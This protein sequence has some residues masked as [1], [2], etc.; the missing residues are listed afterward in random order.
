[1][2]A[3]ILHSASEREKRPISVITPSCDIRIVTSLAAMD[4]IG[5]AWQAL[6]ERCD[7]P[8][9]YFQSFSWCRGWVETFAAEGKAP[10]PFIVTAWRGRE[11]VAIW[12]LMISAAP[13]GVR[14]IETLGEPLSQYCNILYDAERMDDDV[15]QALIAPL[16]RP[17][18]CE[19]AVLNAIPETSPLAR[20]LAFFPPL[21]AYE[22]QSSILDLSVFE[23]SAHYLAGLGKVQK[24][25]RNR[26]RNKL[27]RLGA[28]RLDV[29]WP[30]HPHFADLVRLGVT[31][32]RRWIA[33]TGRYSAG[34]SM[35]GIDQF[36]ARLSGCPKAREGACLSVLRAGE[37][38]VS[39]E[40]GFLLRRHYYS[41]MGSFD[42]D[43]RDLSPGKIQMEMTVCWLIDNGIEAYDL[44]ANPAEYK[45]SWSNREISLK[46]FALPL[47]W[48]GRLYAGTWLTRLRPALKRLWGAAPLALRRML[49]ACQ[50][51]GYLV[52]CMCGL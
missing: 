21:D 24:R 42:W 41:Y 14:R 31:M 36:L 45:Q 49:N 28:L 6:G 27:A 40:L 1:V 22:N 38:V 10:R 12:P 25:N 17:E 34:F 30:D 8:L 47:S 48:R 4:E 2:L 15:A 35:T 5:A 3:G 52:P 51:F 9:T 29:I 33:E 44:L 23:S 13:G 16:L 18:N 26:R 43:L 37:R 20:A 7:N 19:I 50:G 32:K 46:A 11:L 39:L